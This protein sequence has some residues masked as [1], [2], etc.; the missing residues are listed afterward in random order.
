MTGAEVLAP[1]L[2]KP[3]GDGVAWASSDVAPNSEKHD[4]NTSDLFIFNPSF[5]GVSRNEWRLKC[6]CA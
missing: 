1:C 6:K 2:D 4:K 3:E 5:N